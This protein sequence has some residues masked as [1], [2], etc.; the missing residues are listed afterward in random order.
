MNIFEKYTAVADLA[1]V[2]ENEVF[3]SPH[4]SKWIVAI[5]DMGCVHVLERP[6]LHDSFFECGNSAEDI[7]L[8]FETE[9]S[10]GVYEWI[11]DICYQRDWESG[12]ID[13]W[14]FEV[15]EEKLLWT[16]VKD[17]EADEVRNKEA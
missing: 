14:E 6:C 2:D 17:G 8:P 10:P 1:G 5:D 13:G 16:W 4:G 3:E 11:C 9:N 12:Y 15:T 7:G